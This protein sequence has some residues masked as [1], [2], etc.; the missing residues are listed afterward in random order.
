MTRGRVIRTVLIS[1]GIIALSIWGQLWAW[2]RAVAARAVEIAR[3]SAE[4]PP[5]TTTC[6]EAWPVLPIGLIVAGVLWAPL[7]GREK[8]R[9]V[10][11]PSRHVGRAKRKAR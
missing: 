2:D 5:R 9:E 1:I 4:I 3:L 7:L 11:I 8:G 6:C 10:T